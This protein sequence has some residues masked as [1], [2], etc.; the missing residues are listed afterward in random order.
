MLQLPPDLTRGCY[1]VARV[2]LSQYAQSFFESALLDLTVSGEVSAGRTVIDE[3]V[4]CQETLS[5]C[6]VARRKVYLSQEEC[7]IG[8]S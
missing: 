8:I 3:V 2:L 1:E 6:I 7:V 4:L 5:S